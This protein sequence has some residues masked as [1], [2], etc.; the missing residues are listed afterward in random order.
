LK[1]GLDLI[2]VIES[3]TLKTLPS[4]PNLAAQIAAEKVKATL[5]L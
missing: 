2:K 4:L 5:K 3:K 1:A